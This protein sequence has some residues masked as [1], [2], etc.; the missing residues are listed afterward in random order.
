MP[1]SKQAS[2]QVTTSQPLEAANI[3]NM[4]QQPRFRSSLGRETTLPNMYFNA[5]PLEHVR[6]LH[7]FT[8][9]PPVEQLHLAG[10]STYRQDNQHLF[11]RSWLVYSL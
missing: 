8:A 5:L 4:S 10:P 3:R 1:L 6:H 2:F 11:T 9:L 7:N